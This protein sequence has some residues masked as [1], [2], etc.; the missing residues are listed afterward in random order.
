MR[1]QRLTVI[2]PAAV[3]GAAEPVRDAEIARRMAGFGPFE[4]EPE[5]AVAVSGGPDSL[6][7]ALLLQRWTARFG[8]RVH[9]VTLDHGVR[10]ESADEAVWVGEQLAAHGMAHS[11]LTWRPGSDAQVTHAAA[12]TAR[13]ARLAAWCRER[14]ILHLALAHHRDDQA[15]TLLARIRMNTGPDGLAGMPAERAL[16][17]VRLLRPLLDLPKARLEATL[18]ALGQPWVADPLNADLR[19]GRPHIR[20]CLP[21]L[22][23]AG[24]TAERLAA[25]AHAM[26]HARHAMDAARAE[27]AARAVRVLPA[28]YAEVD[29][30]A[31]VNAPEP[32]GGAVLGRVLRTVGGAT[33][34]PRTARLQRL[35]AALREQPARA[36]TLGGC[37][38]V[39][40]RGGWLVLREPGRA[41][42]L[43]V[44]PGQDVSYD[45]R[46]HAIIAGTR[47]AGRALTLGPLGEGGWAALAAQVPELRATALPPPVRPALPA[48][49]DGAGVAEVPGLGWRRSEDAPGLAFW[50]WSPARAVGEA[51]FTVAPA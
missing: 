29:V 8:G 16:R 3:S 34:T 38:I 30:A 37:R 47:G 17:D 48:L 18:A 4:P 33:H 5:I 31:I 19:Y 50:A 26:G 35:L 11:I 44:E 27:L 24:V 28:G 21:Q 39:P 51:I 9:A 36:H 12:R 15:E 6:A 10:S 43:A 49:R 32:V 23:A 22:E 20:A 41:P 2:D 13:Y 46:F 14:G 45:G 1:R 42:T 25:F 7:L 40:R